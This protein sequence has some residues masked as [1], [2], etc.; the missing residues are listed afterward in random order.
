LFFVGE[1]LGVL[2]SS[3]AIL[4]G[5][6]EVGIGLDFGRQLMAHDLDWIVTGQQVCRLSVGD[7][8]LGVTVRPLPSGEAIKVS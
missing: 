5:R 6:N 2:S 3:M 8:L 7:A 1:I 4:D